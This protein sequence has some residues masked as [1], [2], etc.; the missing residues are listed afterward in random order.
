MRIVFILAWRNLWRNKRRTLITVASVFFA[1]I[2]AITAQSFQ[3]G[4]YELMIDNMVKY[5]TGYLQIQDVLFEDEPSMDNS[6]L[7]DAALK[8]SLKPFSSKI[9]YTVPRMQSFALAATNN[10]TRGVVVTGIDPDSENRF[11]NLTGLITEGDFIHAE[12]NAVLVAQGL[13]GMLQVKTG[14]T[15]VLI[16][17]GYQGTMAAGKFPVKGIIKLRVPELNNRSVYMP[18]EAARAFYSAE[19]RLTSLIVMPVNPEDT[20]ELAA[21]IESAVDKEWYK[22]LTWKVMLKDLLRLMEFDVAGNMVIIYIL[23]IVIAF[24]IFGTV[25]TMMIERSKEFGMLIS[26]GMKR[27]QLALIC[28]S[29]SL[30]MSFIGAVAGAASALPVVL[31][32]HYNPIRLEGEMAEMIL[33]YG[34]EPIMPFSLDPAIF[35]TQAWVV[36]G[37]AVIIGMYPV[38]KIFKLRIVDASKK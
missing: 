7:Y 15:L 8:H 23:Y 35:M 11:N 26:L 37:I 27:K 19:E 1:V 32:Y 10:T 24:G 14:D 12:D 29:E 5:S 38:Y 16:S 36:F 33:Q 30:L 31:W 25:L 17:Q 3:K 2:M 22:V 21:E 34:F 20:E 4:S 18:L 9:A 13:A 6:M 28:L